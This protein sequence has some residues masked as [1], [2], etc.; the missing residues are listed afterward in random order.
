MICWL[1][2]HCSLG[3][4]LGS[5]VNWFVCL[6][7]LFVYHLFV[8]FCASLFVHLFVCLFFIHSFV[9]FCLL[10]YP[11]YYYF[12]L[13]ILSYVTSFLQMCEEERSG[14]DFRSSGMLSN[15]QKSN[16]EK[17]QRCKTF[18]Y[19]HFQLFSTFFCFH[20]KMSIW[21]YY[22][23]PLWE[24]FSIFSLTQLLSLLREARDKCK[25]GQVCIF[26]A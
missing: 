7:A 4:F 13:V 18:W 6:F 15:L 23:V 3:S 25:W 14:S 19:L 17:F 16:P 26:Q 24:Y 9:I 10:C 8:R 11:G 12:S 20:G 21:G 22:M 5:F 1:G 2:I